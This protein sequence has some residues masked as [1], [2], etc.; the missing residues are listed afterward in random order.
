MKVVESIPVFERGAFPRSPERQR[1]KEQVLEA[2]RCVDWPQGAGTFTIYPEK[3]T[4]KKGLGGNG[5]LPIKEPCIAKLQEFGWEIE[6]LP[7]IIDGVLGTGDLDALITTSAG[8]IAFEWETGSTESAHRAIDKLLLGLKLGGIIAAI[9]VVPS[10][11]RKLWLTRRVGT[12]SELRP[13]FRLWEDSK[14]HN[15]EGVL[16]VI[17][18]EHDAESFD[19]PRL[20]RY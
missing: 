19:A 17:V 2:V 20:F 7:E 1:A 10:D 18:C 14:L 6:A 5:V 9:L 3:A 4:D 8:R 16:Q 15:D 12:I 13:Y 11:R